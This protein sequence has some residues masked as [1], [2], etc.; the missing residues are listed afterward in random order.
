[1]NDYDDKLFIQCQGDR[2]AQNVGSF[3][4]NWDEE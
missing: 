1:M 4:I 3:S 2:I